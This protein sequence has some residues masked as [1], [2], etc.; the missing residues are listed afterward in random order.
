MINAKL[1]TLL[2]FA[3]FHAFKFWK[4]A[5]PTLRRFSISPPFIHHF[6]TS[7]A[8]HRSLFIVPFPVVKEAESLSGMR[9][10]T[11][12]TFPPWEVNLGMF[13][14]SANLDIF[15]PVVVFNMIYV[16][17]YFFAIKRPSK[18]ITHY[19]SV[20][21]YPS[22]LKGIRVIW[23]EKINIAILDVFSFGSRSSFAAPKCRH[24]NH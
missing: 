20:F 22:I 21:R 10:V 19:K 11:N 18:V 2:G 4:C 12:R 24:A 6:A 16:M 23:K 13:R 1:F 15:Y 14:F 9:L 17:A 3:T 7:N 8:W 5:G